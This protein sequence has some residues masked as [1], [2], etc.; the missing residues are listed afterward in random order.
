MG[1]NLGGAHVP[2]FQA[3]LAEAHA[4]RTK[5][6]EEELGKPVLVMRRVRSKF[7]ALQD[8][9]ATVGAPAR[10]APSRRAAARARAQAVR[11]RGKER[12]LAARRLA[13]LRGP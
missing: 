10:K 1:P 12:A 13:L 2:G 11:T 9:A 8:L 5:C 3:C 4:D 6:F 7:N